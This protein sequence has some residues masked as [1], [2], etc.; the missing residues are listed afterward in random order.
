MSSVRNPRLGGGINK[1]CAINFEPKNFAETFSACVPLVGE[2]IENDCTKNIFQKPQQQCKVQFFCEMMTMINLLT[3]WTLCFF[4]SLKIIFY[5]L[6]CFFE[7]IHLQALPLTLSHTHLLYWW[8]YGIASRGIWSWNRRKD[9]RMLLHVFR[10]P[11][12][13]APWA[14]SGK[15]RIWKKLKVHSTVASSFILG[16]FQFLWNQI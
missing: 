15:P 5:F 14:S 13:S 3:E 11:W 7:I 8:I 16:N 4:S 12:R 10:F 2:E 1:Q 6:F 9:Y